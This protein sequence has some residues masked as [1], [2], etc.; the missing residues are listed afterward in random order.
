MPPSLR[1]PPRR[2]IRRVPP[3]GPVEPSTPLEIPAPPPTPEK[4][5]AYRIWTTDLGLF[6][7][8]QPVV[9]GIDQSLERFGLAAYAPKTGTA[10]L[11]LC[12]PGDIGARR[13]L[14][15]QFFVKSC[16]QQ[17]QLRGCAIEHIC[18]EG[19]SFGSQM[20]REKMGECGGAVKTTLITCLGIANQVAYPT[21][22]T[23]QQLKKFCLGPKQKNVPQSKA[24]ML[25][26]VLKKWGVDLSDDNLADAYTLAHM[27]GRVATGEK[28]L[29]YEDEVIGKLRR[30]TEWEIESKPQRRPRSSGPT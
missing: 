5:S 23:P 29:A 30:H 6:A 14:N 9:V 20:A 27:A 3:E 25:K 24:L 21:I 7:D 15:V 2:P 12:H 19:Y 1:K 22:P 16:I 18:M 28:G 26:G 13:L 17:L 4:G 8:R 11:W 10:F